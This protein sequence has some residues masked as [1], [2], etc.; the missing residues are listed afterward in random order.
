M[1]AEIVTFPNGGAEGIPV[2]RLDCEGEAFDGLAANIAIARARA[3]G[4]HAVWLDNVSSW[5]DAALG[6]YLT[7]ATQTPVDGAPSMLIV[8]VRPLGAREWPQFGVEFVLDA[9]EALASHSTVDALAGYLGGVAQSFPAV[10]DLVV[11]L[12]LSQIPPR[13]ALLDMLLDVVNPAGMGYLYTPAGYPHRAVLLRSVSVCE[14]EWA[15]RG[16]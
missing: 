2:V 4:V 1:K 11:T 15:I 3:P 6:E 16:L 10:E 7:A 9:S 12:G 13:P 14:T 5:S 8:G